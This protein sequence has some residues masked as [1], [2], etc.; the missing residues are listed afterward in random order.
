MHRG[1]LV[2]ALAALVAACDGEPACTR[3]AAISVTL[4]V[5][6]EAGAAIP[7]VTATWRAG[8]GAATPCEPF[9]Q[10]VFA[11]GV[12]VAGEITVTASAPGHAEAS[13]TVTVGA[14]E[15]HVIEEQVTLT[16]AETGCT[17]GNRPSI[18]A[19]VAGAGGETLYDVWVTYQ[20]DGAE[21]PL[22]CDESDGHW[23]CGSEEAGAFTVFAGA[24]GHQ[25]GS[26]EVVVHEDACHVVT[27]DVAFELD[28]L[29]D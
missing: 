7:D 14:D 8:D 17:D 21:A 19:F 12:E 23:L 22:E 20:P 29:P 18:R 28:W 27:E 11:C 9:G 26:A 25:T 4:T 16:L 6:D 5:Q 13:R 24:S 3:L 15:C 2:A 10:G 1:T